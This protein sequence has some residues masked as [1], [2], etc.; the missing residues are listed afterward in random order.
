MA[1]M[2][3][4]IG[5][6]GVFGLVGVHELDSA[7]VFLSTILTFSLN[8]FTI[9]CISSFNRAFVWW[10]LLNGEAFEGK[11]LLTYD[12]RNLGCVWLLFC[13]LDN[14]LWSGRLVYGFFE[15]CLDLGNVVC[16]MQVIFLK[17][18]GK[19]EWTLRTQV[20]EAK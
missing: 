20:N 5:A 4:G 19:R 12:V 18:Y 9:F 6:L 3:L 17:A 11:A 15:M 8:N 10:L 13:L 2:W 16:H 14:Y 1:G 7:R